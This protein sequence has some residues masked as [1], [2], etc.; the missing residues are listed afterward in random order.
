MSLTFYA[1]SNIQDMLSDDKIE[2]EEA[3]FM[4]GYI[5]EMEEGGDKI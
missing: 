5:A 3:A 4:M 1:E 2:P